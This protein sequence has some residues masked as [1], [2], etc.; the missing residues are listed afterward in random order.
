MKVSRKKEI[1]MKNK[2]ADEVLLEATSLFERIIDDDD[3]I[4]DEVD[5][6]EFDDD[7]HP[8][9]AQIVNMVEE[10]RKTLPQGDKDKKLEEFVYSNEF[11]DKFSEDEDAEAIGTLT[12]PLIMAIRNFDF[13]HGANELNNF[14]EY[15]TDKLMQQYK[16]IW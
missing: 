3:V 11:G 16:G 6:L 15:L 7:V 14:V 4:E 1:K 2:K 9:V 5:E 12:M 8:L 10:K 13:E